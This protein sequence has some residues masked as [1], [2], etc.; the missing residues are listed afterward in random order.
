MSTC[1]AGRLGRWE[2]LGRKQRKQKS[3]GAH[4]GPWHYLE[5]K[6]GNG[7]SQRHTPAST[8][9]WRTQDM[10]LLADLGLLGGGGA[11]ALGPLWPCSWPACGPW[12]PGKS[13]D[14][15]ATPIPKQQSSPNPDLPFPPAS[16][17]AARGGS[18]TQ[19]LREGR[20]GPRV[21]RIP[22]PGAGP[23]SAQGLPPLLTACLTWA[24]ALRAIEQT[25]RRRGGT[26]PPVG[27]PEPRSLGH[28]WPSAVGSRICSIAT[29]SGHL[30]K[31]G[32]LSLQGR[33]TSR[34][35]RRNQDKILGCEPR[36]GLAT[37]G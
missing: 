8:E 24:S 11:C 30:Q 23:G 1:W 27:P 9:A 14:A 31:Q 29:A 34:Y 18:A 36:L 2:F 13:V 21:T 7:T 25:Q 16:P 3:R 10:A 4:I 33:E 12:T 6:G 26:R 20:G 35:T 22:S 17:S 32:A 19:W 37:L 5:R 28:H 15:K